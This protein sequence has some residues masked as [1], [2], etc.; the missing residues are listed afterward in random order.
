MNGLELIFTVVGLKCH[1]DIK[2][3]SN[4]PLLLDYIKKDFKVYLLTLILEEF[5]QILI[6]LKYYSYLRI[7]GT[8]KLDRL[9]Q[10]LIIKVRKKINDLSLFEN[11][12]ILYNYSEI[13]WLLT[14]LENEDKELLK[15]LVSTDLWIKKNDLSSKFQ[16]SSVLLV[17]AL[18]ENFLI[19]V[20]DIVVYLLFIQPDSSVAIF[21]TDSRHYFDTINIHR[22]N[23]YWRVY[24][25]EIFLKPKYIYRHIYNL[26]IINNSGICNKIIYLPNSRLKDK[27]TLSKIQSLILLYIE[28]VEFLSP[29]LKS[30]NG[31]SGSGFK[32]MFRRLF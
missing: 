12:K 25:K 20:S 24:I 8:Y 3:V 28:F 4:E 22:N 30:I 26:K 32:K 9:L 10:L 11:K 6:N 15:L 13:H 17:M 29:K 18:L 23:M 19:K 7:G 14:N 1:G 27:E 21:N 16:E 2:N 5:K 31:F